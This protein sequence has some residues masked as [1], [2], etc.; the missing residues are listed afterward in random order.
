MEEI[1]VFLTRLQ[2]YQYFNLI[3]SEG[4]GKNIFETVISG[5]GVTTDQLAEFI[6]IEKDRERL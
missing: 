5:Q 2:Q 3:S 4:T 1:S 6:L